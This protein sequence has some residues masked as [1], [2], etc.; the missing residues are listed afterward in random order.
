[1][2]Y[3][4]RLF[5]ING[6]GKLMAAFFLSYLPFVPVLFCLFR[7][8]V[9]LLIRVFTYSEITLVFSRLTI[10]KD[11]VLFTLHNLNLQIDNPSWRKH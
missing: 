4:L 10:K 5:L 1:M 7:E 11:Y 3:L 9:N 2:N 8:H 6:H